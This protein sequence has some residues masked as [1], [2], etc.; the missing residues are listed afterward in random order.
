MTVRDDFDRLLTV[1]LDETAGVGAPDYL[2]E[3]LDGLARL[4]QRPAWMSPG[5]WLPMQLQMT[6]VEIPRLLP[7]LVFVAL[8][9][10][11][12][13]GA[14]LLV[15]SQRP[16]PPPFGVADNG[17][18]AYLS[19]GVILT[20][21]PDG[22]DP[23]GLGLPGIVNGVPLWSR[24]GTRLAFL[25]YTDPTR[26]QIPSLLVANA[27]GSNVV[28]M[29]EDAEA[30]LHVAWSPDGRTLALS[31]WIVFDGQRDRIFLAASDG[32]TVPYQI[33]DPVLSAFYPAF[34]PDGSRI[35]FISDH[36]PD[37]C[38]EGDCVGDDS[39]ALHIMA[40]DGSTVRTLTSG[41]IQP[42]VEVERAGRIVDW[43]PD[44]SVILFSGVDTNTGD[45]GVYAIDPN[46]GPA[47]RI[48]QL[49]GSALGASFD[50]AGDRIA[51]L[52]A[53]TPRS[54]GAL[55]DVVVANVDGDDPRVVANGVARSAPQ[56]SPDGRFLAVIDTPSGGQAAVRLLALDGGEPTVIPVTTLAD[57][58]LGPGLEP[59]AWQRR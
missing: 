33:G 44:G 32:S 12:L 13:V 39:F 5:R 9:I 34:S 27:D 8:L 55:W 14:A 24:D 15:G 18:I 23:T 26:S 6:R 58:P 21:D 20:A 10:A 51:Y 28:T 40:S 22:S 41:R 38:S 49:G 30:L 4:E 48:D 46:G 35:A 50:P 52:Q 1:W 45:F 31:R 25:A 2:D 36:Y 3:T 56:W 54:D 17:R 59:I 42:R 37:F 16:L 29:V 7:I 19:N 11:A 57:S 53:S 47:A 43:R